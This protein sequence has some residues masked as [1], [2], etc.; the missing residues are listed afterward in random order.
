[1]IRLEEIGYM[2]LHS[3]KKYIMSYDMPYYKITYDYLVRKDSKM[4]QYRRNMIGYD[5]HMIYFV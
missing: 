1:M 3:M 2:V 4:V 5:K